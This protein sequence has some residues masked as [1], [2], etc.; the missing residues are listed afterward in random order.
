MLQLYDKA[1]M[2][3]TTMAVREFIAPS[4]LITNSTMANS[5]IAMDD[6][7]LPYEPVIK[8]VVISVVRRGNGMAAGDEPDPSANAPPA[9]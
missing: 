1:Q 2:T 8:G 3:K 9:P 6:A 4:L 5:V 7:G